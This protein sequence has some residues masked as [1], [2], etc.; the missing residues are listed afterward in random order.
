MPVVNRSTCWHVDPPVTCDQSVGHTLDFGLTRDLPFLTAFTAPLVLGICA[1][2]M[3]GIGGDSVC[4]A[5]V[6]PAG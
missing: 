3:L 6:G 1:A 5:G 2:A 4:R